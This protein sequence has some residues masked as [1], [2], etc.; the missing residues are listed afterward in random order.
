MR[1]RHYRARVWLSENE[2]KKFIRNVEKTGLSKETY[3]RQLIT[4]YK[5][6]SLPASE[7]LDAIKSLTNACNSLINISFEKS[8]CTN[9]VQYNHLS[10]ILQDALLSLHRL[11]N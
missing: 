9:I 8:D 1:Q 6:K 11:I 10:T 4:G 2:Y 5:P 3:L 7:L